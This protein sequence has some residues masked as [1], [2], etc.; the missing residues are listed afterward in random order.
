MG[1]IF[2]MTATLIS[3]VVFAALDNA[4]VQICCLT[5]VAFTILGALDD[6]I[7]Q[8]TERNGL[9]VRQKLVAQLTIG[10]IIS[11]WMYLVHRDHPI[12]TSLVWPLGNLMIPLGIL[13]I[14]WALF[15]VV[16]MCNAVNLTDGLDGLAPGCTVF[17][18][19]AF[20]VL[21]YLCGHSVLSDYLKIPHQPGAGELAVVAGSLVGAMLGFLWF[22]T[23]PAKVFMGDAGALPTGALLATIAL[24]IRQEILLV[25]IGGIFVVE[26]AS[27]VL[28]VGCYRVFGKRPLRC[29]PL[30]NHFVFRGD[31]ESRIVVR[32]W[33][34]AALLAIAGLA[35]LKLH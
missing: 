32:F 7:K 31:P 22:N 29:S 11:V 8:R 3:T 16:S 35:S 19:S 9:T 12:G 17:C 18:G 33:I 2:I 24:A 14:L 1:G 25:V 23:H 27:V 26:T 21:A 10:G 15:V 20:A 5:I 13:F 30:H 4:A 28:Q 6:W 34:V